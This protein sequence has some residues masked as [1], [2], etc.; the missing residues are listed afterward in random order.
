MQPINKRTDG[1]IFIIFEQSRI[2]KGPQH[3][4]SAHKFLAQKLVVDIKT[5]R[6]GGSVEIRTVYE[7]RKPF[8]FVKHPKVSF[9]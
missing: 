1:G 8:V 3:L 7:Q 5:Q 4:S 2:I 6:L 9:W